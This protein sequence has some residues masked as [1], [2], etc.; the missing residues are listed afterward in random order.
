[1]RLFNSPFKASLVSLFI[2]EVFVILAKTVMQTTITPEAL[3][4]AGAAGFFIPLIFSYGIT[5]YRNHVE[6]QNY[7]LQNLY[8]SLQS[9]N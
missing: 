1:M 4:I 6:N 2:T 5:S 3:F 9:Q 8:T 7:E